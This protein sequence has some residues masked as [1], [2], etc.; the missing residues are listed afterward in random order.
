MRGASGAVHGSSDIWSS[1][2]GAQVWSSFGKIGVRAQLYETIDARQQPCIG[3]EVAT[4]NRQAIQKAT[5]PTRERILASAYRLFM[6]RGIAHVGVDAIVADSGCAKA[7]LYNYFCSKE[8]LALAF[9]E[10]RE[11]LWTRAWLEE[12]VRR[13]T[14]DP[15][16]R[17]I[18]IFDLFDEWFHKKDFEGCSFI[19][20]LLESEY[21]SPVH[22]AAAHHL[23]NIQAIV[24]GFAMDAGLDDSAGF[25][26]VWHI[27]MKGSIVT[28]GEGNR[29]AAKS[30]QRAGRAILETWPRLVQ[31]PAR[32]AAAGGG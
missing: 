1:L 10:Q 15:E 30:A 27:L 4:V 21:N 25:A 23:G 2:T 5:R 24:R 11:S 7:S 16:G 17:L 20:V 22:R 14:A 19:S 26:Q 31:M 18:A 32:P 3:N 28:A 12:E 8:E 29:D 6:S 13:R 9:L